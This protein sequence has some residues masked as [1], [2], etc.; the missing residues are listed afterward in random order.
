MACPS[1]SSMGEFF[2]YNYAS[3]PGR[4]REFYK[5]YKGLKKENESNKK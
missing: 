4:V 2:I 1:G 3:P 5:Y